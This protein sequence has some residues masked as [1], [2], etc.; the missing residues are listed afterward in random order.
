MDA[1][2]CAVMANDCR[3]VASLPPVPKECATAVM[4]EQQPHVS[5]NSLLADNT[6]Q[7]ESQNGMAAYNSWAAF[8]HRNPVRLHI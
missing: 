2:I 4:A 7:S 1:D 3:L 8:L 5:G 6:T